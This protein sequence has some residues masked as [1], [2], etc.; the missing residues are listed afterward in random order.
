ME[1]VHFRQLIKAD[2][3]E[4]TRS[5]SECLSTIERIRQGGDLKQ[6]DRQRFVLDYIRPRG[7]KRP[8]GEVVARAIELAG[9]GKSGTEI[10][11]EL[12]DK[13]I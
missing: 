5:I 11:A 13:S 2:V 12:E 9:M 4:V 10:N 6:A 8:A 7:L 3:L 1:A